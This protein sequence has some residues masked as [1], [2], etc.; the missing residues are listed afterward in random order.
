MDDKTC[1]Q[2]TPSASLEEQILNPNIPKNEREWWASKHIKYLRD[3]VIAERNADL[4]QLHTRVTELEKE[5]DGLEELC[6]RLG[7]ALEQIAWLTV[8]GTKGNNLANAALA[9]WREMK[10]QP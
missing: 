3:E 8:S 5:R 2:A 4:E 10:G 1:K 7:E 6:D 9:A